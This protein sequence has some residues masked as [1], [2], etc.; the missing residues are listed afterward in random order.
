M[1]DPYLPQVA[2]ITNK[3]KETNDIYLFTMKLKSGSILNFNPGQFVLAGIP[4]FGESAFDVC[5][6]STAFCP[7][8]QQRSALQEHG[9]L[10]KAIA[11]KQTFQICVRNVGVNTAKIVALKIGESMFVRGPFGNGF[12]LEKFEGKNLLLIGGGTGIIVIRGLMQYFLTMKQWNNESLKQTPNS[13]PG[14]STKLQIFYGARDWKSMLFKDEFD[15]WKKI[16]NVHL[17]LENP[18]EGKSCFKGL[19][20]DLFEIVPIIE[21]PTIIMCGPPVM[22]KFCLE[23]IKEKLQVPDNEIYLSLERRM[24]CG[25]G[26]CQHCAIGDKYVCKDGPVFTYD[27]LKKIKNSI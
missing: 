7:P 2:I 22:Y 23:K 18:H 5:S 21:K 26:I 20:T 3:H 1:K 6:A 9:V 8:G 27:E 13:A 12:P 4:G 25:I 10:P 16:A 24:H 19:I 14:Q 15:S 17:I 11:I